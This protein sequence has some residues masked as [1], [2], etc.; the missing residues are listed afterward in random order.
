MPSLKYPNETV[1]ILEELFVQVF[2]HAIAESDF[3][4]LSVL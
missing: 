2:L 3:A 1:F 4:S